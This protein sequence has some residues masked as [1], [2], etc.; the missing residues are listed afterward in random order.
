M[1]MSEMLNELIERGLVSTPTQNAVPQIP[2]NYLYIQ[3]TMTYGVNLT[4]D[5]SVD[6]ENAELERRT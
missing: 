6:D 2:D 4:V 5:Y 1:K 3:T